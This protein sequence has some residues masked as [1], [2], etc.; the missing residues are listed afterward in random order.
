M[1]YLPKETFNFW[2]N[3]QLPQIYP[4]PLSRFE[5]RLSL[6][7]LSFSAILYPLLTEYLPYFPWCQIILSSKGEKLR[8]MTLIISSVVSV[9]LFPR[10]RTF[11]LQRPEILHL[12]SSYEERGLILILLGILHSLIN[13]ETK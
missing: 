4:L 3:L 6:I 9:C 1:K 13:C 5:L 12:F 8:G 2:W 11:S 7:N 10:T